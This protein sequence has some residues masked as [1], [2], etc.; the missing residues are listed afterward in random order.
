TLMALNRPAALAAIIACNPGDEVAQAR[1]R[2]VLNA[3]GSLHDILNATASER[4]PWLIGE[5]VY[6]VVCEVLANTPPL[7][8]K[9][10]PRP[11]E[12]RVSDTVATALHRALDAAAPDRRS[13]MR[14]LDAYFDK[15]PAKGAT[16][17][18]FD[19]ALDRA[20]D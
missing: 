12:G 14:G 13:W 5:T 10:T 7:R 4:E 18:D 20:L 2:K 9:R 19:A 16:E 17:Q 6:K 15:L 1:G 3:K 8:L 11:Y